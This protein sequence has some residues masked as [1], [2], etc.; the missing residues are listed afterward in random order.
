[1]DSAKLLKEIG[2]VVSV[3]AKLL[4]HRQRGRLAPLFLGM[5]LSCGR[6]TATSWFRAAGVSDQFQQ[7]YYLLATIGRKTRAL[8]AFW[9]RI[10]IPRFVRD[11]RLVLVLDDTPT[12]RYGPKVQGAG[13]HHNPTPGPADQKFVYGH[14]WVTLGVAVVHPLW[15]TLCI[16]WLASLYIRAKD[17]GKLPKNTKRKFKTKLELAI[18]LVEWAHRMLKSMGIQV[19]VVADGAYAKRTFLMGMRERGITVVSRLRK[20]AALYSVP[21][22]RQPGQRG[23]PR[24]FGA[25][26]INLSARA[27]DRRGWKQG[28]FQVYGKL[29]PKKYKTFE[30]TYR[31]ADGPIRVVLVRDA[32]SAIALF[33]TNPGATVEEIIT[34]YSERSSIEQTF[35]D[36]KE[37]HGAGEQQLRNLDAN[38]GAF[39][40]ILWLH[41]MITWWSWDKTDAELVDRSASPW[42]NR[43]RQP[44]HAD[45][46]KAL[47][48]KCIESAISF[49]SASWPSE[50]KIHRL[51]ATLLRMAA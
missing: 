3:L 50:S 23:R 1:M 21:G 16:P 42:D 12:K 45:C 28:E 40:L 22:P 13:V 2:E 5:L 8:A 15:K 27:K 30:A 46:Y 6:R 47:R 49:V 31:P 19:T 43:P 26:R 37:V 20:D 4:D 10:A 51:V 36:I 17:I 7:Y 38:V 44:S 24:K 29:E 18:E 39:N 11:G 34:T 14:I 33:T 48:R 41:G 25:E 9:F 32:D 35:H